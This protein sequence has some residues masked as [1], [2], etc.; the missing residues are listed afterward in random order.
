METTSCIKKREGANY[1][2]AQDH[3]SIKLSSHQTNGTLCD[4]KDP[5]KNVFQLKEKRDD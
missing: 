1:D 2:Y 3:C 4:G 5:E